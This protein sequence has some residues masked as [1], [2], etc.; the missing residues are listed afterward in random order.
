MR[1]CREKLELATNVHRTCMVCN[2]VVILHRSVSAA[3]MDSSCARTLRRDAPSCFSMSATFSS[4]PTVLLSASACRSL[5]ARS[6]D[7]I[8]GLTD[9]DGVV[10][11]IQSKPIQSNSFFFLELFVIMSCVLLVKV[12]EVQLNST[13]FNSSVWVASGSYTCFDVGHGFGVLSGGAPVQRQ[14]FC[15]ILVPFLVRRS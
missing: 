1:G 8:G 5:T 13:D 12:A 11:K 7:W 2:L 3:C 6:C 9:H 4:R 15:H 14:L 10:F